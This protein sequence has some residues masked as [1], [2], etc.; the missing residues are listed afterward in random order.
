MFE[1][2]RR[3]KCTWSSDMGYLILMPNFQRLINRRITQLS[4]V[5]K[6]HNMSTGSRV[7]GVQECENSRKVVDDVTKCARFLRKPKV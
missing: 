1:V 7:N 5:V 3:I 4:W 6:G 2:C